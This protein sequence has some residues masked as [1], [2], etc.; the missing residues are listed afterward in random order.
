MLFRSVSQSRYAV[1][2]HDFDYVIGD[3][4][5]L[6]ECARSNA[7]DNYEDDGYFD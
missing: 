4:D 1:I 3:Y 2:E 7:I 5:W 6:D